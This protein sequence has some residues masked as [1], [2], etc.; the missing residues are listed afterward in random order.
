MSNGDRVESEAGRGK[1]SLPADW[2]RRDAMPTLDS[3]HEE[4]ASVMASGWTWRWRCCRCCCCCCCCCCG[5][6]GI[7]ITNRSAFTLI[8][9]LDQGDEAIYK[10]RTYRDNWAKGTCMLYAIDFQIRNNITRPIRIVCKKKIKSCLNFCGPNFWLAL[11]HM[12]CLP[13]G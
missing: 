13:N 2:L 4:C 6:W 1:R 5:R 12:P 8:H 7:P 10:T 3:A 9:P 11:R